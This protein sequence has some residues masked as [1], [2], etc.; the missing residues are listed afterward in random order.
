MGERFARLG[1]GRSPRQ[2]YPLGPAHA[3][4]GQGE[5]HRAV[6][7]IKARHA[8]A[9]RD[10]RDRARGLVGGWRWATSTQACS[11]TGHHEAY[12]G[13]EERQRSKHSDKHKADSPLDPT[14][15][16]RLC[17][18]RGGIG[19]PVRISHRLSL[20]EKRGVLARGTPRA[21]ALVASPV[22]AGNG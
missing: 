13:N 4:R 20:R 12:Q 3:D 5:R 14:S 2:G 7:P 6:R 18:S 8:F 15:A 1:L 22:P 16:R 19:G 21:S 9:F 11:F 17:C 10:V